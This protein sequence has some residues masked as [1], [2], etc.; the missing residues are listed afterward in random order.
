M[1][2]C[3][4]RQTFVLSCLMTQYNSALD[5]HGDG[6][7]DVEMELVG[8]IINYVL[9]GIFAVELAISLYAHWWRPFFTS[10]WKIFD[11]VIV[12]VSLLALTSWTPIPPEVA[13]AMRIFRVFGTAESLRRIISPLVSSIIPVA[14]AFAILFVVLAFGTSH[15]AAG[16]ASV[17]SFTASSGWGLGRQSA[18]AM[19]IARRR[20]RPL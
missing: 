3:A 13:R 9:S 8:T 4:S 16:A 18:A 11:L 7:Y 19:V 17:D 1:R 2:T 15:I 5:T 10:G 12:I 20:W 6:S 14:N